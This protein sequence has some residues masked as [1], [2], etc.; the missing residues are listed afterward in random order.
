MSKKR[1][2]E[3]GKKLKEQGIELSNQELVEKLHQLGYDVKSHSSSLEDDQAASAYEK[4]VGERKPKPAPVRP[5]GPGFVVRSACTSSRRR[6]PCTRSRRRARRVLRGGAGRRGDRREASGAEAAAASEPA[7]V[8]EAPVQESPRPRPRPS[9]PRSPAPSHPSSPIRLRR[10]RPRRRRLRRAPWR[11]RP[12]RT[13]PPRPARVRPCPADAHP[14]PGIAP[15]RRV[16]PVPSRRRPW[17]QRTPVSRGSRRR[18]SHAAPDVDAGRR[19]LASARA[20]PPRDAAVVRAPAIPGRSRPRAL[21]EV[22]EL[23][24]VPGSL[25]REREFIDVSKDKRRG[26]RTPGRPVSEEAAKNLSGKELL[27]AA[28]TAR[29][30]IPIRGKKKRSTKKGEDADHREGRAQEG[31]PD[32][33]VDLGLGALAGH[34]RQG[35]R[36]HPQADAGR[37]DGHDQQADRRATPRRSWPPSSATPS[38]RRASRSRSTSSR[39]R[40]TSRS[41]SSV[42]RS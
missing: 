22:R 8:D 26:G 10:Q 34:G 11:R 19:H 5:S 9:R 16:R 1:V 38:R 12:R 36:P 28:I 35:V 33:G 32:R 40:S 27:Q 37:H 13:A 42:R 7:L 25:G 6:S 17:P 21:G 41:W 14:S 4:I 24:V 39:S 23:K 29:A 18:T 20:G 2:H 30:Y 31:H 3:L 15:V